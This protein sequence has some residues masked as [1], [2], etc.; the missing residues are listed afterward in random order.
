MDSGL[1]I[2]HLS[3]TLLYFYVAE[4]TVCLLNYWWFIK[5]ES[6]IF[7]TML[8][9]AHVGFNVLGTLVF[10]FVSSPFLFWPY[11]YANQMPPQS[12]KSSIYFCLYTIYFLHDF[13]LWAIEFWVV[14]KYGWLSVIQGVSLLL[15]TFA[16]AYGTF[17]VWLS[18]AWKCSRTLQYY[19]GMT[20]SMNAISLSEGALRATRL[21]GVQ[22]I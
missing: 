17:A 20:P 1:R 5:Y 12:R 8:V 21:D 13:P 16:A 9:N 3:L 14:W 11:R 6:N 15:L 10:L 2:P 18:Y 22:R 7:G 19:Y 4:G